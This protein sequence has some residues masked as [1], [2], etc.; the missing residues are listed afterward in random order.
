MIKSISTKKGMI[1]IREASIA[2]VDQYRELRLYALQE[3]PIAFGQDYETSLSYQ[4]EHWHN[5]LRQDNHSITFIAEYDNKLMGMTGIMRRPLPKAKHSATIIGV[6]VHPE[7]RGLRIADALI[8][9]CIEWAKSKE[10]VV[11]KLSVNASNT[12]AIRCYERCG[13]I[14]YGTEPRSLF[15]DG[16]YYGS[17]LMYKDLDGL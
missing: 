10:V 7:W 16:N 11:V 5:R 12:S 14:T 2:D 6:F 17:Y 13:F 9:A 8:E 1:I 3:S 4:T 15:Y